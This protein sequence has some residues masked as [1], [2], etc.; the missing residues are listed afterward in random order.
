[1]NTLINTIRVFTIATI[2]FCLC[3][4]ACPVNATVLYWDNHGTSASGSGTWDLTTAEWAPTATLTAS[5]VAWNTADAAGFTAGTNLG[6]VTI[7]VNTANL[8]CAGVFNGA[9]SD[10]GITNLIISGSGSLNLVNAGVQEGFE[11]GANFNTMIRV[12]VTGTG[13]IQWQGGGGSLYLSVANTYS[14]GTSL[15]T[16]NGCNFNNNGAFGSGSITNT[17]T[18][19]VLA[20]PATDNSGAAFA[21]APITIANPVQTLASASSSL[22]FVGIAA[23]PT[24]FSGPWTL[25]NAAGTTFTLQSQPAGT[26][27]NISGAISGAGNFTKTGAGTLALSGASTYTG[28]TVINNGVL[29][30]TSFN[31]V[32]GGSASSSLGAP[33]TVANG[34]IGIGSTTTAA[35]LIYAGIGETSDRVI[36]LAGTTGGATIEADGT[37]PLVLSSALT[38]T[39]AGAKT[40]TLQGSSAGAN[41]IS[42]AIVNSSSAT[43]VTKAQSGT[44]VLSGAS[45]YTG[46]T[47]V[48]AGTLLVDGSLASGSAAAVSAGATLGGTGTINGTVN[49]AANAVL[50]AGDPANSGGIGTLTLANSSATALTLNGNFVKCDLSTTAGASDLIAVTGTLVLNGANYITLSTPLGAAPAGTYT[51]M[52]Y[53]AKTGSGTL[54]LDQAYPNATLTVGATSVTLTITGTGTTGSLTWLGDGSANAWNTTATGDWLVSSTAATYADGQPVIFDDSSTNLTVNINPNAVMPASV[55]IN[56]SANAYTISGAGI[57]GTTA[58]TK[59]GSATLT[60]SGANTYSGPTTIAGGTVSAASLNYISSGSL[61]PNTSSSLGA[62]TTT[63]NG[64]ISIGSLTTGGALTYTG[65]GETSDRVINLAGTTGGATINQSGTGSLKLTSALTATGAGAKTLTIQGSTAGTGEFNGAIGDSGGGATSVTKSG[66]DTWTLSGANTYSGVTTISGGILSVSSLNSVS[67]GSASSSLGAPVTAGNGTIGIGSTTTAGTLVYTGV[68]ETSDRVINLAGTTGGATIENDGTGPVTFSSS[69]TATGAGAKTLT[70]QGTS[71]G[72]NTISGVI[73]NSSSATALTKA[74]AGTW[75][76]SGANTYTGG[77]TVSGGTLSVNSIA[78]SGT[79]ALSTSG[80]LTLSGGKLQYTGTGAATTTRTVTLSGSSSTIDLPNGDLAISGQVKSGTFTKTSAGTLTLSGSS[81]DVALGINVNGGTVILNKASAATVHGIGA[82][83]AVNN[84]GTLQLSGSGGLELSNNV[85]LTVNSGGIFDV[86]SQNATFTSLALSG[87]GSGS[88][89]LINSSTTAT[90]ALTC[91]AATAFNLAAD[92]TIGGPGSITLSG[93]MAGSHALTYAGSGVLKL[94]GTNAYTG[95]TTI[96]SGTLTLGANASINSTPAISIAAGATLDVSAISSFILSASTTL[97]AAGAAT[98]ATINGASGGTVSL[99]SRPVVLTYDGADPALTISQGTL[100]L[101]GNAFTVNT[102]SPL[103]LGQYT[104][105]SQTGGSITASGNFTVAGTAFGAGTSGSISVVGGN[106]ILNVLTATTTTVVLSSGSNPS[107]YGNPLTFQA[108]ISPAP[109]DGETVTFK[110]N[111]ATIGT[112]TTAGGVATLT[113]GN[114][115]AGADSITAIYPGDTLY[116]ASASSALPQ[117]V[118]QATPTFTLLSSESPSG[119]NDALTFVATN[120]PTDATSNIVFTAN[121]LPFS[122]NLLANGGATSIVITNLPRGTN[123]IAA[124]Y[125]GDNNYT[126][127]I[128]SLN[129]VVTNHPP[130]AGAASYTRNAAIHQ[131]KIA[132]SDLLTN[133]TDV[134]GDTNTLVGTSVSTNGVT[135]TTSGGYLFY[136]DANPV[137]DQFTYTVTD[138][139]GG[140]NSAVVTI[141]VDTTPLFGQASLAVDTTG[142]TATLN[143]AGI[144]GYSYSVARSTDLINWTVIWTTNAPPGGVFQ[145]TDSAPPQPSAYYQLEYNNQ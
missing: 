84:G 50:S 49:A 7:T 18:T 109:A 3:L 59:Y 71:T 110:N 120:F 116:G 77:T 90:S 97:N 127:A 11:V 76:L 145:F 10:G 94:L 118:N 65:T 82:N 37:G 16:A 93:K 105:V 58:V 86:N 69:F 139:Y 27:V 113:I 101:N 15:D 117:T 78:D 128:T 75:V 52:T 46:A 121:S 60:L 80:G 19:T 44:W 53:G 34:T 144:P 106:V 79:S 25:E 83:S 36:N 41:T 28:Q 67:G 13:G 74:Q 142:G 104:I 8:G 66:S 17:V 123:V 61:N 85:A 108:T 6:T 31:K 56:N 45:T 23:A 132:I 143:F 26:L 12:P 126:I 89:A 100:V 124:N 98:A 103:A 133:A 87:N 29:S 33:V 9:L 55:E 111:V 70:L 62:P 119:F 138:G 107:I 73:V 136:N 68:G 130:V 99:G 122:T 2:T 131:L 14:G 38:A 129:Q 102:A 115:I 64:T 57:G 54:V 63:A 114:L 140:T 88:G 1:M 135:L 43:A 21:T 92:S 112:G 47:T 32:S 141:N 91:S 4:W 137:A 95:N 20:T 24:T 81:D 35:S 42:G 72:A 5:T 22:I 40:L 30:V 96:S 39:G 125:V 134:D 51:L 48:S